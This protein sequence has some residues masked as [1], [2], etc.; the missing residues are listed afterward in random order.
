MMFYAQQFAL[1]V[2]LLVLVDCARKA[3]GPWGWLVAVFEVA[4]VFAVLAVVGA[5]FLKIFG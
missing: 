5:L 2:Y 4:A 1:F 3:R